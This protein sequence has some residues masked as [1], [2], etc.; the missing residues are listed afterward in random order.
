MLEKET[1]QSVITP[2]NAIDFGKLIDDVS[3]EVSSKKHE[4]KENEE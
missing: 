3:K 2:K 4:D 1:E